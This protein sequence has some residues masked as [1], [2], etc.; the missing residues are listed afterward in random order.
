MPVTL[1][2]TGGLLRLSKYVFSFFD[3]SEEGFLIVFSEHYPED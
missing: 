2:V 1:I 3:L